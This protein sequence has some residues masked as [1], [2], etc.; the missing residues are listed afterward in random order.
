MRLLVLFCSSG[1]HRV[2]AAD[3]GDDPVSS[4]LQRGAPLPAGTE[5]HADNPTPGGAGQVSMG[6][7]AGFPPLHALQHVPRPPG[8][9]PHLVHR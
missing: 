5:R 6:T 4:R 8:T 9:A 7:A 1:R 2:T 3:V